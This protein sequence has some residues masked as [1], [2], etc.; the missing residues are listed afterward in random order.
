METIGGQIKGNL[1]RLPDGFWTNKFN[2]RIFLDKIAN[3]FSLRNP[4]EWGRITKYQIKE[5]GGAPLL[6]KYKNSLSSTLKDVYSEIDWK[7]DWFIN[8]RAK[9]RFWEDTANQRKFLEGL[10]QKLHTHEPQLWGKVPIE[11]VIRNGGS[12]LMRKY[13]YS[14]YEALVTNFPGK[15]RSNQNLTVRNTLEK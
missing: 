2:Q 1:S 9:Y 4:K 3:K 15:T 5:E 8:R 7:S 14:L 12:G 10:S 13:K 6:N 11:Q